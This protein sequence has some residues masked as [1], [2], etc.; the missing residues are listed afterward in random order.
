MGNDALIL[1]QDIAARGAARV[2]GAGRRFS[3]SS[4]TETPESN[5][6]TSCDSWMGCGAE[7][8]IHSHAAGVVIIRRNF[9]FGAGGASSRATKAA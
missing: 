2:V 5:A 7:S 9:A 4:R 1:T 6:V 8:D 3:Q